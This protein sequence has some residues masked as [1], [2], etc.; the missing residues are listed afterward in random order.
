MNLI[1]CRFYPNKTYKIIFGDTYKKTK[2]KKKE[3]GLST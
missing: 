3:K 2:K 1:M